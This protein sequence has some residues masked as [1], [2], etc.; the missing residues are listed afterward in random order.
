MAEGGADP[1]R[2]LQVIRAHSYLI[3]LVNCDS[4]T[5]EDRVSV[6]DVI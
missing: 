3:F 1:D 6:L 2:V 5:E 4:Y